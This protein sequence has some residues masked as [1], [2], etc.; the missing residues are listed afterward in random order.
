MRFSHVTLMVSEV[1]RSRAFYLQLGFELIVDTAHYCRF[2]PTIGDGDGTVSIEQHHGPIAS[3]AQLGLEFSSA[4]DLDAYVATLRARGIDIAEAP[5]DR[6]W[7]W[8]DA[9]V[10]DPDRHEWMLFFAGPN[11]LHPPWRVAPAARG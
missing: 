10:F 3:G 4:V 2:L 1:P 6:P 8:R 11:K 5:I 7:L 9:R